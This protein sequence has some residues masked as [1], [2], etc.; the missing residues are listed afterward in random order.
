MPF[1][2]S[3][4]IN[5]FNVFPTFH[6]RRRSSPK[7]GRDKSFSNRAP[8]S[9][10][11][12]LR[13]R[14]SVGAAA[15][16]PR[17]QRRPSILNLFSPRAVTSGPSILNLFSPRAVTS[18]VEERP[19]QLKEFQLSVEPAGKLQQPGDRTQNSNQKMNE[20]KDLLVPPAAAS[21]HRTGGSTPRLV[22]RRLVRYHTHS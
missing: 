2:I 14:G 20:E 5:S 18:V 3:I 8:P 11:S 19:S 15:P 21:P 13:R 10:L 6:A 4:C 9:P 17:T 1:Y 16:S 22:V 7:L 12:A